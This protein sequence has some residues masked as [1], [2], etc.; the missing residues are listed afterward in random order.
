VIASARSPYG[1]FDWPNNPGGSDSII[2]EFN[3]FLINN[4]MTVGEALY[5]AK[6]YCNFHY[7]WDHYAE[8]LDMYT[9]NLF[10]EPSLVLEGITS[11]NLPPD[12]PMITGPSNGKI[13]IAIEYNYT[14]IDPDGDTISYFIDWGDG[15]DSGWIGPYAS[16]DVIPQSHT[17]SKKG[18]YT[19]KAKAKDS[20][21]NE[22]DWGELSVTMPFS[23]NIP[24][25]FF[26]QRIFERFPN[27]F[28]ILRYFMG[29]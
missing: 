14:T 21:G 27:A 18:D 29:Y 13:R 1:S 11:Q 4:S 9:F 22:G 3:R 20:Y 19:I 2:Y 6:Y 16:G 15:T 17:W 26:W 10:G 23:Y 25:M 8:Y 12:T 28:P 5:D 7:G 24:F